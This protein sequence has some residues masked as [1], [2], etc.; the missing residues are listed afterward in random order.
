MKKFI[1]AAAFILA[2]IACDAQYFNDYNTFINGSARLVQK[3][4]Y[5]EFRNGELVP[6]L[7]PTT[8]TLDLRINTAQGDIVTVTTRNPLT[9]HATLVDRYRASVLTIMGDDEVGYTVMDTSN[10]VYLRLL[11]IDGVFIMDRE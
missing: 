10:R 4:V 11:P 9:R 7:R 6:F 5:G 2:A 8:V 3:T 1:F